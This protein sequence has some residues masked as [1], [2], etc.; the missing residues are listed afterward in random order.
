MA[1]N[2]SR[3]F[4]TQGLICG[5]L[6]EVN[7]YRGTTLTNRAT[8]LATQL[9]TTAVY[10]ELTSGVEENC[11]PAKTAMNPWVSYLQSL[12]LA[13]LIE[14]VT[15][16]RLLTDESLSSVV[17]E[18]ARQMVNDSE[19][20]NDCPSTATVAS[21]G[22]PTGNHTIVCSVYDGLTGKA[23]DFILA[24]VYNTI[25]T[26]DRSNGGTAYAETFGFVGK[27]ADTS[28]TDSTYPQ[29]TG[30][31]TTFT[32]VDP[33]DDGGLITDPSFEGSWISTN[34]PPTPW[35]I[36]TGTAGTHVKR[37]ASDPRTGSNALH[38][39]GDG[40]VIAKVIQ[41]VDVQ[42]FTVYNVHARLYKVNDPGTDWAVSLILT[43]GSGNVVSGPGS[44][45]N[46]VSSSAC[47]SITGDWLNTVTGQFIGPAV[48]PTSGLYLEIRFHQSGATTTAAANTAAVYVD[49]VACVEA[50]SLYSG[51]PAVTIFS[52][53]LEGVVG[54][55]RSVT[56]AL[57]SGSVS[58]YLIRG[59]DRLLGLAALGVRIPTVSGGSETR[60]DSLVA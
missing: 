17:T 54:D 15:A 53:T 46:T 60:A 26:A 19:S 23:S 40:S 57:S 5:A 4:T 51:G 16:D 30:I 3:L 29:G 9:K 59:M 7:T 34:T 50:E 36:R 2:Y 41:A 35:S 28:P 10:D 55:E 42:P 37:V 25:I 48:V 45:S 52:G 24:D 6:N 18:L 27:A 13:A 47:S 14:D 12:S 43:D 20:L 49:H 33:G 22:S 1:I 21:I 31:S 8:T 44:Y 38:L 11:D 32:A 56:L 39:V 58:S